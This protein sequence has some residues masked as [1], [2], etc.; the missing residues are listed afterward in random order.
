MYVLAG[1]VAAELENMQKVFRNEVEN[2]KNEIR[3]REEECN[4]QQEELVTV[5]KNIELHLRGGGRRINRIIIV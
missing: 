1:D 5:R 4:L 2:H 3:R